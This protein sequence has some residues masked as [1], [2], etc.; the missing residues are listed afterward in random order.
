VVHRGRKGWRDEWR[1]RKGESEETKGSKRE[2]S[3]SM[4]VKCSDINDS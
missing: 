2:Y 4:F 3:S 1:E